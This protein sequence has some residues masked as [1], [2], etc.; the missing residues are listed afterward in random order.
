M[1]Y[2]SFKIKKETCSLAPKVL[3]LLKPSVEKRKVKKRE[4]LL[5]KIIEAYQTFFPL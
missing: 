3:S 2:F 1:V 5:S 4:P